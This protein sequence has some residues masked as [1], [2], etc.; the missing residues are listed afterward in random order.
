M[1]MKLLP[2]QTEQ[3]YQLEYFKNFISFMQAVVCIQR[4][5]Q[6]LMFTY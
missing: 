6:M 2:L 5:T 3:Y 4:K 1:L